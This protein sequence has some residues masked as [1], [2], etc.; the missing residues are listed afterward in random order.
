MLARVQK[1]IWDRMPR[2]EVGTDR[3][4]KMGIEFV[5]TRQV[6]FV[7]VGA[8]A[9]DETGG[10]VRVARFEPIE[11]F[12]PSR[13]YVQRNMRL[14]AADSFHAEGAA[15]DTLLV[16]FPQLKIGDPN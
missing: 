7:V 9:I 13:R 16:S 5:L 14:I 11:S 6:A 4:Q 12:E 15:L 8:I 3:R 1:Q 2:D 10:E